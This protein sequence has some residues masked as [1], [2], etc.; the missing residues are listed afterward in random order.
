MWHLPQL[1][2]NF[3]RGYLPGDWCT[4]EQWLARP[5]ETKLRLIQLI[6]ELGC[7]LFGSQTEKLE[8]VDIAFNTL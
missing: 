8:F 5:R 4:S 2:R 1:M 7:F 3:G 6:H